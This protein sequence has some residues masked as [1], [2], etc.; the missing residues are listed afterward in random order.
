MLRDE[1]ESYLD[2]FLKCSTF[3]DYCPNGL[4]VEGRAHVDV[5][6]TGVTASFAL[7]EA[8]VNAGADA[9]LV[10]HGYFWKGEDARLVGT[11]R[12]RIALLLA[13][14]LNL[15]A[16]HLPLDAHPEVG[17]NAMLALQLGLQVEGRFGDQDIA[18]H[19]RLAQAMR[20]GDLADLLGT[21]L[22][23]PP[24]LIGDRARTVQ[25][26]AWCTGAAQGYLEEAVRLG[27][28][29]YISGEVS[30][31][32]YHLA[33]ESGVAF[34]GAGHHATERYGVQALGQHLANRFG[35]QHRYIEIPNPV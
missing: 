26:I 21:R 31:Q 30:E 11:R 13:R 23:R 6:A 5:I 2:E 32:T 34:L 17:N 18:A 9:L 10:H 12:E 24:L 27:V 29:A 20:L 8:A 15:F 19:G 3:R 14:D 7:I 22:G 25:R 28:D 16:Y 35:L 33:C 1:L 4:Q